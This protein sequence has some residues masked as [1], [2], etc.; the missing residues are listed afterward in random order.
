VEYERLDAKDQRRLSQPFPAA[1]PAWQEAR[2]VRWLS[3]GTVDLL[4]PAAAT[5]LLFVT[6]LVLTS[7]NEHPVLRVHPSPTA[8]FVR[9]LVPLAVAV[10]VVLSVYRPWPALVAVLALTPVWNSAQFQI[11]VGPVQIILQTVFV[12]ALLAGCCLEWRQSKRSNRSAAN[13]DPLAQPLPVTVS[14]P[15]Q[16]VG[17]RRHY[18]AIRFAEAA[19]ILLLVLAV[20]STLAS[21]NIGNSVNG[22]IHGIAEP[23]AFGA[24]LVWLKPSPRGI[25]LVAGALAVALAL[26]SLIDVLQAIKAYGSLTQIVNHRLLFTEVTYDNVGLFGVIIA[27]VLPLLAAILLLRRDLGIPRWGVVPLVVAGALSLTGLFFS[28]S[29]SAWLAT[30]FGLTLL[31]L[32]LMHSWWKRLATTLAVVALSAVFIPWPAFLLQVAPPADNAYRSVV[33][34]MVGES[35]FDSW[36]PTTLSGHGSMAERY[37][38]IEGGLDMAV[39]NPVLG[40]GLNE[41]HTYYMTL[42]YRPA[43]ARDDLDHAHS[44]FPEVA[45]ELGFPALVMLLAMF[46]AALWAMWRTYRTALDNVTRT[47]AAMLIASIVAWAIAATAY[48]ADIYRAFRDQASDIVALAVVVAMTIA[49]ARWIRASG[50]SA[51][52][53]FETAE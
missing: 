12:A 23:I 28:I 21:P 46:A 26:G 25:V 10:V 17:H 2:R 16:A 44:V 19:A 20:A 43:G 7:L 14:V 52:E 22:L 32:L 47:L 34:A 50:H 51:A 5:M 41:F 24:I 45:A 31:L 38:A 1:A 4:V 40:V 42:G 15:A 35:R 39:A 37:Y 33:I 8:D 9:S 53:A 13:G 6:A 3:Q 27:T 30:A 11:Q 49:L 18:E 29:K 36:N 48:G